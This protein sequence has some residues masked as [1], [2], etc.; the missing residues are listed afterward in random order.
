[1]AI[2]SYLKKSPTRGSYSFRRR[3]PPDLQKQWGK[4]EEKCSLKTKNHAE[5]LRRGAMYNTQFD[6]RV[7]LLRKLSRGAPVSSEQMAAEAREILV[8][9][10][11]HPQQLPIGDI[12]KGFQ[13][14]N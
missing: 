8:K 9:R 10:G 5:A 7:E 12:E 2:P 13:F 6:E 14:S 11:L 3:V 4:L 1:M